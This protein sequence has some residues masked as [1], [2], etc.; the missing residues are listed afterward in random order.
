MNGV[1][2]GGGVGRDWGSVWGVPAIPDCPLDQRGDHRPAESGS[3]QRTGRTHAGEQ[4][5][6]P[7]SRTRNADR[8]TGA[9]RPVPGDAAGGRTHDAP[10]SRGIEPTDRGRTVMDR[11][12]LALAV[13]KG[14]AGPEHDRLVLDI[15]DEMRIRDE[16]QT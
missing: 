7:E 10:G 2:T 4:G 13:I 16:L 5:R 3:G 14:D 15:L 12:R 1:D 9:G 11:L 6:R 8:G